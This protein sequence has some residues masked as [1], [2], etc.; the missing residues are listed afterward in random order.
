MLYHHLRKN[1]LEYLVPPEFMAILSHD[2]HVNLSRNMSIISELRKIFATFKLAE[3]SFIVLKGIALAE[4]VYSNIGMRGMGDVDLM[5]RKRD[6]FKVD[7]LLATT[8]YRPIDSTAVKAFHNPEGYL[9]SL[10]YHHDSSSPLILHIHWHPVNT[11][12]PAT[13]FSARIDLDRLWK[14]AITVRIA[15]IETQI[16]RPE[17]L[18]MYLCEHALRVG[19]SFNHLSLVCDIFFS[20]K[21]FENAI[22]WN[23]IYEESLHFNLSR[24]VYYGLSIVKHYTA[25]DIPDSCMD[26]LKPRDISMGEV[27]FLRLQRS[28]RRIRGSSYFIYL[29]MN[30]GLSRKL[31]F[32]T[33]TFFPPL[34]ILF[35][36]RYGNRLQSAH[37]YYA[38]RIWEVFS[39]IANILTIGQRHVR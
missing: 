25:L 24:F 19:H 20:I 39:S 27:F 14:Q 30:K 38:A 28:N 33:R 22:D 29:A 15:D 17:H 32:I 1:N 2:F 35:Q 23:F 3:I 34:P 16:F 37:S 10:E 4:C 13:A 31:R 36:R 11:S 12:V 26:K 9:T 6:L 21:T 7:R 18:I 5:I 8:V